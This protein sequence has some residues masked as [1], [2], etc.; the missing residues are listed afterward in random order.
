MKTNMSIAL[1]YLLAK[2]LIEF[3]K[4]L[5]SSEE[6]DTLCPDRITVLNCSEEW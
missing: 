1:K 6:M 4:G 2:K 3:A 5:V